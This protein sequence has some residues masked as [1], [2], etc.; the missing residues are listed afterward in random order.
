MGILNYRKEIGGIIMCKYCEPINDQSKWCKSIA[1][2]GVENATIVY[3]GDA[4]Y[5]GISGRIFAISA[6]ISFCPFCAKRLPSKRKPIE[7]EYK[8]THQSDTNLRH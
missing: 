1:D 8:P 7:P 2:T 4:A 5:I 3:V 6:P